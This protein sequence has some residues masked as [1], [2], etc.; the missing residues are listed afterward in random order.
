VSAPP[1][2]ARARAAAAELGFTKS[3][4]DEDGRLL[5]VLA[6]GRGIERVA[7]IG[8][9]A[10]VGTAWLAAALPPGVPL[11]TAEQD[12]ELAAAARSLF[13][14]DHDVNVLIGNW[15]VVLPPHA[16]F[17]LVFVDDG[18]AKDDPDAAVGLAAP[19]ATVVMDDFSADWDGPDE[20]RACWLSHPRLV[21]VEVGTGGAAQALVAVV[22]R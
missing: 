19:G 2:V 16:P 1:L 15:R 13:A 8:T 10:G 20:R 11:F 12:E 7:E 3:C 6:G 21:T 22:R 5:H 17:D 9:G 4:R 18:G 14:D